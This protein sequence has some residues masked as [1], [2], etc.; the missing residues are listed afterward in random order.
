M[1]ALAVPVAA[2]LA[3][4]A[5]A[6]APRNYLIGNA[7]AGL[8][9]IVF[10]VLLPLPR[11]ERG[12]ALLAAAA[13]AVLGV[14]AVAGIESQGMHRWLALGPL[15]LHAGALVLPTI[16]VLAATMPPRRGAL[17]LT[18][19]G[20][21]TALQPDPAMA[22]AVLAAAAAL[23]ARRL[24]GDLRLLAAL[25]V[26]AAALAIALARDVPLEPVAFVE[27]VARVGLY[28]PPLPV[29]AQ[30]AIG[31]VLTLL[32]LAPAL[33]EAT[34]R[35][36]ARGLSAFWLVTVA[37]ATLWPY[38]SPLTGFGAGPIVGLGLA[39]AALR[40]RAGG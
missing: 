18:A 16:T 17:L 6:D 38:P 5:W 4:M 36:A 34:H 19:A 35:H 8:V 3:W 32:A 31:L 2:G 25:G 30:I 22:A 39:L 21:A 13:V 23:F 28:G 11:G 40:S 1:L 27:Q 12:T 24:R 20:L 9:A 26:L 37:I 10:A 14:T 33:L 15:R 7:A 29:L